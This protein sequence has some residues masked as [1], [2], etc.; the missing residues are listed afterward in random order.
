[1]EQLGAGLDPAISPIRLPAVLDA[2]R[3]GPFAYSVVEP[4][5]DDARR[6]SADD[7][8]LVLRALAVFGAGRGRAHHA[9][10]PDRTGTT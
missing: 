2:G 3:C 5:P 7:E 10:G 4:L 1:M 8:A 9:V 6:V